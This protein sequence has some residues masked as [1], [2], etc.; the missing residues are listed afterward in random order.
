MAE[1]RIPLH[2]GLIMD[3]NGRWAKKRLMPRSYGH[4]SGMNR[5]IGLAEHAQKVGVKYLTVYTLSTEN[6]SRPREEL[7][8]LFG[9][10]RK[11][12]KT[13]VKKL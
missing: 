6:L 9:L 7:D 11:Y 2:V 1:S 5:M 3:G 8:G 13:N 4:K 10:F 12:F